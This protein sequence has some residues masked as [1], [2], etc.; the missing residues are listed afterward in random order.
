ME[1]L[2]VVLVNFRASLLF[3][4]LA[5]EESGRYIVKP[6]TLMNAWSSML[7]FRKVFPDK[8]YGVLRFAFLA[9]VAKKFSVCVLNEKDEVVAF[10]FFRISGQDMRD[11]TVHESF[12]GVHPLYTGCGLAT[13][14][15]S[16]SIRSL[17]K[18]GYKGISSRILLSNIG[19]LK[20]AEKL[21]F[22]LVNSYPVSSGQNEGYFVLKF[23]KY[24]W[25]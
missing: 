21:G 13:C 8:P 11:G 15:R 20:S 16:F 3:K 14:L 5:L 22:E 4:P 9:V 18:N 24:G 19:S 25:L 17:K 7:L 6:M 2:K 10:E 1:L 12:V 23:D